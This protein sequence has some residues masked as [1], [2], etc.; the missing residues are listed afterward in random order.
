[1]EWGGG[2][3]NLKGLQHSGSWGALHEIGHNMGQGANGIF[4]LPGNSEVICNFY[5]TCTMN[6]L[7]GTS[8]KRIKKEAWDNVAKKV[9]ARTPDLW[10]KSQVFDR[11]VFYMTLAH[12]FGVES[13]INVVN[14]KNDKYPAN[15]TGDRMCCAWSKAVQRDLTPYFEMWGL[16]LSKAAYTYTQ[17][18]APWPS[19]EDKAAIFAQPTEYRGETIEV[20]IDTRNPEDI[21][22]RRQL[23]AREHFK[24]TVKE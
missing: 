20:E 3:M 19:D 4:A 14:D 23:R 21:P 8:F 7:N 1:M 22:T 9:A 11:L 24:K 12:Y 15:A 17:D 10:M 18:W 2:M 16:A 5:G 13:V 6:L